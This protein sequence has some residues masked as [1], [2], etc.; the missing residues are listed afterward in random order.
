MKKL[1]FLFFTL[2]LTLLNPVFA[3]R[4]SSNCTYKGVPL[5]G[6]VKIVD[7]FEDFRVRRVSAFEDLRVKE[8]TSFPNSC[9]RWQYVET[10]P[11]F[12][13]K[14][15]DSFEDFSIRSVNSFEGL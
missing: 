7:G 9:G 14:F 6:R 11:D 12:R 5:Y 4:V 2:I 13:V 8:V 3:S 1:S 15:V 10:F